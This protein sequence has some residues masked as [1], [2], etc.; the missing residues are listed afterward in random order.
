MGADRLTIRGTTPGELRIIISR[1]DVL[2]HHQ[3]AHTDPGNPGRSGRGAGRITETRPWWMLPVLGQHL[4]V[5]GAT[6]AGKGS[7]LWSLIAGL[8]PESG[9]AG[10]GYG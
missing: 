5:A 6:G 2:G 9:V 1:G 7:V 4:L 10:C 3:R 8:A